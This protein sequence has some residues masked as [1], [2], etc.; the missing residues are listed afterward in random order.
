MLKRRLLRIE[1]CA[2]VQ[3][4]IAN[5]FPMNGVDQISASA[6]RSEL[7]ASFPGSDF[8]SSIV[9]DGSS[10]RHFRCAEVLSALEKCI[11]CKFSEDL[12]EQ[13][14][15]SEGLV[16]P[17][18]PHLAKKSRH[19]AKLTE[20]EDE[21]KELKKLPLVMRK[22]EKRVGNLEC[23]V[24]TALSTIESKREHSILDETSRLSRQRSHSEHTTTAKW[25]GATFS[26]AAHEK[27]VVISRERDASCVPRMSEQ[28]VDH[29]SVGTFDCTSIT[30]PSSHVR[31]KGSELDHPLRYVLGKILF[32][33]VIR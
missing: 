27:K 2:V 13:F 6:L 7:S 1:E 8:A 31:S 14:R 22:Q 25:T 10:T 33:S 11:K 23:D 20:I 17:D 15:S 24:E 30:F 29:R 5:L 18:P 19:E 28:P 16:E 3:S 9:P 4:F 12:E 26:T 32:R 21:L